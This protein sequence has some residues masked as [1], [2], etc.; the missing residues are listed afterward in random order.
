MPPDLGEKKLQEIEVVKLWPEYTY[1]LWTEQEEWLASLLCNVENRT[2]EEP[3][4]YYSIGCICMVLSV[5]SFKKKLKIE[6]KLN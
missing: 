2:C 5:I 4:N 1:P 6:N 3:F